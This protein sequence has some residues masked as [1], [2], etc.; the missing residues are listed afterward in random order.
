MASVVND[1][2]QIVPTCEEKEDV[3]KPP[4]CIAQSGSFLALIYIQKSL[5]IRDT[6]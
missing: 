1:Y 5:I 6:F 2:W 3:N 4:F